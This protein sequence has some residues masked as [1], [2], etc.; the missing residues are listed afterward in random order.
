[1]CPHCVMNVT[2]ALQTLPGVESA[3]VTLDDG[4]AVVTGPVE[5]ENLVNA[6]IEAGYSVESAES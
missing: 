1:T 5:Q 2:K 3:E 6:V 4:Q